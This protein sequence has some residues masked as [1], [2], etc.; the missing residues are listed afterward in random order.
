MTSRERVLTALH[1][2]EPDRVPVSEYLFS[3]R[4]QKEI[5]GYTT[6]LYDGE[7]QVRLAEKLELDSVWIAINGFCGLEEEPHEAGS[8]YM[9][10][11]GITYVK[12]G[13]PIMV[14]TAV[15][16]HSREDWNAYRI[17]DPNAAHRTKMIRD[18]LR[19]NENELAVIVG[20][21]GP[22][23]MMYWYLMDLETLSYTL[24]EDPKLI[25]TMCNAYTRW[26]LRCA[27]LAV[28]AGEIDVFNI[29]DDWGG[30]T[31][32]LISPAHLREFF[33]GP[34][35]DI[36]RG[37][38]ALGKPVIMHNDGRIWDVLDD[39]VAT[40]INGYHPVERAAGMDLGLV[41]QR[42]GGKLCPVGNVDNKTTLV[43]GTP[44]DV[45]REALDCLRTAAP[46]GGYILASDHS[47]HDDI[48]TENVHA[49]IGAAKKYGK[50]PLMF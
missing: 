13:W 28:D 26:V 49:L 3:P 20:L 27:R 6:E 9:D 46:G 24:Y 2:G 50:Y 4:L 11:W 22:L 14:Q 35:R 39:L 37:L 30:T 7:S 16:I 43:N 21:L 42:Y 44:Q 8:T 47:F 23:T 19:A 5:L 17:P 25:H 12:N 33:I 15:P 45:E 10:E 48:P 40:G 29:S 1:C 41:K 36:V 18:A 38:Q 32:L 31:S 34:F